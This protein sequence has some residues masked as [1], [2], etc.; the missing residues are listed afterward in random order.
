MSSWLWRLECLVR[1]WTQNYEPPNTH[2]VCPADRYKWS[3][4]SPLE[5]AKLTWI[6]GFS[7]E[8]SGVITNPT[9]IAGL[10]GHTLQV[11]SR[12]LCSVFDASMSL[13]CPVQQAGALQHF[14]WKLG[15][16]EMSSDQLEDHPS[17]DRSKFGFEIRQICLETSGFY[18]KR[19][20]CDFSN[21]QWSKSMLREY[22]AYHDHWR[23][24]F[25]TWGKFLK[26]L[27]LSTLVLVGVLISLVISIFCRLGRTKQRDVHQKEQNA[28]AWLILW[29]GFSYTFNL[30]WNA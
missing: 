18:I 2:K 19:K 28:P 3:E 5:M 16:K 7:L 17:K 25:V 10:Y 30:W 14:E 23:G 22:E 26:M 1:V 13:L 29:K 21:H 20:S 11:I 6:T 4:I 12:G 8:I 24:R 27:G 15:R 9:C